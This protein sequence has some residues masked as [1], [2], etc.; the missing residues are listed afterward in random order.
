MNAELFLSRHDGNFW[1]TLNVTHEGIT[2]NFKITSDDQSTDPAGETE[3][4]DR[5]SIVGMPRLCNVQAVRKRNLRDGLGLTPCSG[6]GVV[7]AART[8]PAVFSLT[9]YVTFDRETRTTQ[10][11]FAI[12]NAH[13]SR[14]TLTAFFSECLPSLNL[15]LL[16]VEPATAV[17]PWTAVRPRARARPFSDHDHVFPPLPLTPILCYCFTDAA[18]RQGRRAGPAAR[19]GCRSC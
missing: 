6:A 12:L 8:T 2:A 11:S 7:G 3:P 13:V 17:E 19:V 1:K 14:I 5:Q 15:E 9:S 10:T 18:E 16:N 4:S